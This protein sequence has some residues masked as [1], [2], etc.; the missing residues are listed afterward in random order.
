MTTIVIGTTP[1]I[2]YS[3]TLNEPFTPSTHLEYSITNVVADH[4]IVVSIADNNALYVKL[5]GAWK[6]VEKAYKKVNGSWVEQDIK[7][8]FSSS[9]K[10]VRG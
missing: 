6:A 3:I 7:T 1:T 10:Y 5:N 9:G 8:I 4:T 2:I